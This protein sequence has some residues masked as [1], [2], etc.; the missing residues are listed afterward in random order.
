MMATSVATG[1]TGR[2]D[3]IALIQRE[4]KRRASANLC[5]SDGREICADNEWTEGLICTRCSFLTFAKRPSSVVFLLF[6]I[7]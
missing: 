7:K 4:E 3:V 5:R 1:L 2:E 6:L